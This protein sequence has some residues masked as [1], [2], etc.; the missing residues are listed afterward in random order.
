MTRDEQIRKVLEGGPE[1]RERFAAGEEV[2]ELL[3]Q[4]IR[5]AEDSVPPSPDPFGYVRTGI[6]G[7]LWDT[8]DEPRE[9][10]PL[11]PALLRAALEEVK[12]REQ[13]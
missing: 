1:Q 12:R 5:E 13:P 11:V 9:E 10:D 6:L 3:G 8:V 4:M 2:H 7:E